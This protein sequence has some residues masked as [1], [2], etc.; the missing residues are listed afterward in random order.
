MIN[1]IEDGEELLFDQSNEKFVNVEVKMIEES[2]VFKSRGNLTL[3]L[4]VVSKAD[5]D[6]KSLIKDIRILLNTRHRAG[7]KDE[8]GMTLIDPKFKY[9]TV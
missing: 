1:K 4:E 6:V 7:T 2:R 8:Y 3:K 9:V 5:I